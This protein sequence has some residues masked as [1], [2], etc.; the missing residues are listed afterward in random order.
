[1]IR[2]RVDDFPG[3]KPDEFDRHNFDGFLR[4]HETVR[5]HTAAMYLLG[6]IPKHVSDEDLRRLPE[7]GV[8]VGMHGVDHDERFQNEFRD[9]YASGEVESTLRIAR[10]RLSDLARQPVDV[11]MPP[12]NV[13]DGRTIAACAAVGFKAITAGPETVPFMRQIVERHGL[14]YLY[15]DAPLEYGRSDELLARGSVKH[16]VSSLDEDPILTL[17][18]TWEYNVGLSNL[19]TYLERLSSSFGDFRFG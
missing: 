4:F 17:H 6:V 14:E 11:Y 3:A 18:W 8:V 1:M 16:L 13:I 2:L 7:L 9:Y 12:H 5:E 19:D 10:G 15:S